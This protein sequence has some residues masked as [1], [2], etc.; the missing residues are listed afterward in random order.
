MAVHYF[1]HVHYNSEGNEGE[2]QIQ[3]K[4]VHLHTSS[5]IWVLQVCCETGMYTDLY[6]WVSEGG[7]REWGLQTMM[8]HLIIYQQLFMGYPMYYLELLFVSAYIYMLYFVCLEE[9]VTYA[10][11]LS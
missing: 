4:F 5:S 1:Q 10:S 6:K 2:K 7:R 9:V 8:K 3:G 11:N